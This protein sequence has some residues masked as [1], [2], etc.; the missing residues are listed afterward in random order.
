MR[1]PGRSCCAFSMH[2][3]A[4][5]HH[6]VVIALIENPPNI[7]LFVITRLRTRAGTDVPVYIRWRDEIHIYE[8]KIILG[9]KT[10]SFR[11]DQLKEF[12]LFFGIVFEKLKSF[13]LWRPQS[14]QKP[15]ARRQ[16]EKWHISIT[17][18][19]LSVRSAHAR[20]AV[21]VIWVWQVRGSHSTDN[22]TWEIN[23]I[24]VSLLLTIYV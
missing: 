22:V 19:S 14:L 21:A 11:I 4:H 3:M 24:Q 2:V 1:R 13:A 6:N 15:S 9:L 17:E 7:V 16:R 5:A 8:S 18:V 23:C 12:C 20:I 10:V